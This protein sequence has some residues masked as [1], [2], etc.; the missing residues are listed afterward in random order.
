MAAI[1]LTRRPRPAPDPPRTLDMTKHYAGIDLGG[2]NLKLG[3]VTAEGEVVARH[4]CP[5]EAEGGAD[6]VLARMADAVRDLCD[7]AGVDL[8]DVPAV[9]VG[10]PGPLDTR[11]GV[12]VFS[13][14]LKWHDVPVRDR[15][16]A[17]LDRPV[18]LENDAN[19]AA[20][21]EFR[22]GAG[23]EVDTL[24]VLTLGTGVGGGMILD[25]RLYRGTNDTGAELG[26]LI[27]AHGGRRCACGA[28]GC[29][30][31][32]ASATAVLDRTR[33]RI[34]A[35]E[36]SSL[37]GAFTSKDVFDAA[38]AGDALAAE[39]V[40]ETAGYLGAGITSILHAVNPQR[41]ALAG[42]MAGAG[43]PFLARIRAAVD[44]LAFERA[45]KVVT[46]VY[47]ALGDDAGLIGAALAAEAFDRT[48]APA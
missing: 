24:V 21:G 14:N 47:T 43:E 28:E 20:Y 3:L 16:R 23:R 45:R 26:H 46:I 6:H 35:G 37:A 2:T 11:A 15:L 42:G 18:V 44:R 39:I 10:S 30:E 12:V 32:Y 4:R 31:A 25:G 5:T 41:V 29:L 1:A 27:V 22:C 19:A 7:T 40:E 17:A 34:E 38:T 9:G 48:G 33:E 36:A 13:P 8:A